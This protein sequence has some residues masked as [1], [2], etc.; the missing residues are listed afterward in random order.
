V[1][2]LLFASLMAALFL[3]PTDAEN[4]ADDQP[5]QYDTAYKLVQKKYEI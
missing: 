4:A 1:K 5:I 2:N 3:F